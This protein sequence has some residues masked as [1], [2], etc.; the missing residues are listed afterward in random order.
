MNDR[1][2]RSLEGVVITFPDGRKGELLEINNN[3]F[4]READFVIKGS[5]GIYGGKE[6]MPHGDFQGGTKVTSYLF[7]KYFKESGGEE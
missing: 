3:G 4:C 1:E 5:E 7:G 6:V 2:E